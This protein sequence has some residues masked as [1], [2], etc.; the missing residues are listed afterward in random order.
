MTMMRP[1]ETS[2]IDIRSRDDAQKHTTKSEI[3]K[4]QYAAPNVTRAV[5]LDRATGSPHLRL[6]M[7]TPRQNNG[8][9]RCFGLIVAAGISQSTDQSRL[10]CAHQNLSNHEQPSRT[11]FEFDHIIPVATGCE[12]GR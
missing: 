6:D 2:M 8:F 12:R 10:A 1:Q 4:T 11:K 7:T 5:S 3:G 9:H